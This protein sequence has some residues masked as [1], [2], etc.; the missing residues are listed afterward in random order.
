MT[1]ARTRRMAFVL[2]ALLAGGRI[3]AYADGSSSA[4][5]EQG[6]ARAA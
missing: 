3:A 1:L 5:P 6:A 4:A 2:V